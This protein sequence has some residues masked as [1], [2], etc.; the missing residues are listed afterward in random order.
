MLAGPALAQPKRAAPLQLVTGNYPPYEYEEDGRVRG[1]AVD[2][3]TEAFKRCGQPFTIKVVPWARALREAQEGSADAIFT[4]V[5]T[6]EREQALL[7]THEPIIA[8]VVSLFVR[9]DAG[10]AYTG[11]LAPLA[12]LRFGTVNQFSN[13]ALFDGAVKS[14]LIKKAEV[15]NE[16]DNNVKKLLASRIDVMVNNR[17]GAI[18]FLKKNQALAQ[19]VELAPE[20]DNSPGYLAFTKKR[21][22]S[23]LAQAYDAALEAMKRD[24]SYR[25]ILERYTH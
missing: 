23:K 2:I 10:I 18:H 8:L 7:F 20:V 12:Q 5:K 22:F 17:Y 16:T 25:R 13:G 14:G 15:V 19:V 4:A 1:L 9:K 3:L 24:G 6:P 21:D 11:D